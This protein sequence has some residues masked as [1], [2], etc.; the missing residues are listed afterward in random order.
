MKNALTKP[1]DRIRRINALHAEVEKTT[2]QIM[3]L[4]DLAV[5]I[6]AKCGAEL[7]AF[8]DELPHGQFE[9]QVG[10]A[11]NF[12]V[13]TAQRYM[14]LTEEL[15][16]RFPKNDTM[17]LLTI[18]IE[19]LA[20]TVNRLIEGQTLTQLMF[21]WGIL[22]KKSKR[23]AASTESADDDGPRDA[24]VRQ[25]EKWLDQVEQTLVLTSLHV[26]NL[27]R[28][29]LNRFNH[30]CENALRAVNPARKF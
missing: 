21:D 14:A 16:R 11:C 22:K 3:G 19:K 29:Q 30:A 24:A 20:P 6:A 18:S 23:I 13:R 27:D 5:A 26:R 10:R 15:Q 17:S 9:E 25:T 1:N 28:A 12:T 7:L 8:K 4:K 2:G